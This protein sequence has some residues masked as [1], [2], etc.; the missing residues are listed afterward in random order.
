MELQWVVCTQA[1]IEARLEKVRQG[2]SLIRKEECV[3]AQRAHGNADLFE[4]EQVL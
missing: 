3:V 4:V 2:I 1:D